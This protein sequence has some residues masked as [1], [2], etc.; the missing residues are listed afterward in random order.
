MVKMPCRAAAISKAALAIFCCVIVGMGLRYVAF[1]NLGSKLDSI[2]GKGQRKKSP[3]PIAKRPPPIG[4]QVGNRAPEIEGE[5]IQ[6]AKFKLSDYR[7]K[8]VM[9]DFWGNW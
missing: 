2:F 9:L 7:G 5:D 3:D 8:V 1:P 4:I 6:G